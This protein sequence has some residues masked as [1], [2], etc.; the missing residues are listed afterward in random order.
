MNYES[1]AFSEFKFELGQL[2][3]HRA[4]EDTVGLVVRRILV[5]AQNGNTGHV[6]SVAVAAGVYATE[7][8]EIELE[9]VEGDDG[10]DVAS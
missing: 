7:V 4:E 5:Q 8:L 1:R 6:Y 9:A 10:A 2:V 3:R